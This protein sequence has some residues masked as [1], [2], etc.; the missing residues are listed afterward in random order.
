MS[1][2]SLLPEAWLTA[3]GLKSDSKPGD[4]RPDDD[5]QWQA[6]VLSDKDADKSKLTITFP[7]PTVVEKVLLL[8]QFEQVVVDLLRQSAD[9]GT[10]VQMVVSGDESVPSKVQ[11]FVEGDD[12]LRFI[13]ITITPESSVN[14]STASLDMKVWAC[15]KEIGEYDQP[16]VLNNSS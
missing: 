4:I 16:N 9:D 3:S 10:D 12:N 14:G 7:T 15:I 11:D 13:S 1:D 8:G 6:T 5:A 2:P